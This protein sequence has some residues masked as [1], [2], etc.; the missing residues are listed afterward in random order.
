MAAALFD[1]E[2]LITF[3]AQQVRLGFDNASLEADLPYIIHLL[4]AE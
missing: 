1:I 4:S 3:S 2:Q